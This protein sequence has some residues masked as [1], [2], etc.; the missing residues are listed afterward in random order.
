[1]LPR[2]LVLLALLAVSVA[3][4]SAAFAAPVAPGD[5]EGPRLQGRYEVDY[6]RKSFE[7]Q[8]WNITPKCGAGACD[9]KLN[10]TDVDGT[11]NY[12]SGPQE[13][14]IHNSYKGGVC[15]RKGDDGKREVVLRDSLLYHETLTIDKYGVT[16][17]VA[18]RAGGRID[19]I[20]KP[21]AKA[22]RLGCTNSLSSKTKFTLVLP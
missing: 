14:V 18:T 11:L 4:G 6:K 15:T 22:K 8:V 5:P 9:A 12:K 19:A 10:G 16:G 17:E 1:M 20:A 13:Y 7:D 21:T 3:G 2:A